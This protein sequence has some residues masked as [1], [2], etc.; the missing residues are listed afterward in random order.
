MKYL[1]R[2]NSGEENVMSQAG[3]VQGPSPSQ[4]GGLGV[5]P[6]ELGVG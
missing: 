2:I 5:L 1:L 4:S 6:L 3:L